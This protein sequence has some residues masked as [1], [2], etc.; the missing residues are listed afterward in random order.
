M[1]RRILFTAAIGAALTV[2]LAV[3]A[4]AAQPRAWHAPRTAYGQPDLQG[5]WSSASLTSLER[6]AGTPL[7][8]ATRAEEDAFARAALG[9]WRRGEAEGPDGLGQG[10][11]EWHHE[12]G[13]ARVG[14]RLRTSWIVSPADGRLPWS[15]E[16]QARWQ[17][18]GAVQMGEAADNPEDRSVFDRCLVGGLGSAN[19]PMLNPTVAAVKQIVQTKDEVAILSE[20]NHDVR[21]VRMGA[22]HLPAQL[23][24]WM[25]DSIGRWEGETLVVETT[26]FHPLEAFRGRI[27]I[28]PAARVTE[29]FTRVGPR[30]LLYAF[31]VDD[32]ANYTAVWKGEMPLVAD[33]GPIYEYACHEGNYS[34]PNILAGARA[35][36]QAAGASRP[37]AH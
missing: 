37:S 19:P 16:G 31:E 3:A 2:G 25:G 8:F 11:S 18:L 7:N 9:D 33:T 34:L 21:V 28:S 32:P 22:R 30:E 26:G 14:G 1:V 13:F 20:M 24:P 29:R 35:E 5:F 36:E 12:F 6:A 4:A 23:R 27:L 10:V 17:A 15:P